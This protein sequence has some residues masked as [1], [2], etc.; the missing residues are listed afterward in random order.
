VRKDNR[1]IAGLIIIPAIRKSRLPSGGKAITLA[2]VVIVI[3]VVGI[4]I[5][6]ITVLLVYFNDYGNFSVYDDEYGLIDKNVI[7]F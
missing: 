6:V 5:I 3:T 4:V 2:I 1:S 7:D